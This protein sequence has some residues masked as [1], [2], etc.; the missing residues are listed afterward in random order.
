[1]KKR[2]TKQIQTGLLSLFAGFLVLFVQPVMAAQTFEFKQVTDNVY[3]YI[4]SLENRTP[5]NLGLN[6][7]I[8]LV[9]TSEGA[10][11]IDSGAGIP[12]AQALEKAVKN[13]TQQPI[14]AVINTG[15][16]D[17]RWL[18]NG[19]FADKGA[20]IIA[21]QHTVNTQQEMG[22]GLVDKMTKVSD[23]FATT[24]PV[25]S[26]APLSGDN[27]L[28][29]IGDT[30]FELK[31]F[32]DAHFPGDAVVWLPKQNVL[33]SG[34]LIYVDRMLGV[35]PFSN[36]MSWQ[37]AFHQAEKMPA[38]YIVPGHGQIADWDLARKDTG[39]Y[40]DK[41]VTVMTQASEDMMGVG[42]VVAAN[43]DWPEF[44]HLKHYDSWH[45]RILS[46][47]FLQFEEA[48]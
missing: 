37:Q 42:D 35:H 38:K 34:D 9:L 30:Q 48:M 33:F 3:A 17:H 21:L 20:K 1:M 26:K 39:D 44:T 5:E 7:N 2:I 13:I 40:L 16:Q 32:G 6:N 14:V 28:L 41:L 29:T 43:A 45:K 24:V 18:G 27:A 47:T 31:Y 8:G 25:V 4:G 23:I 22:A 12:S 15:S 10:V 46:R 11:L 36:V 19:Y